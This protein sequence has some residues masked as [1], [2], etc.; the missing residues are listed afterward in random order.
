MTISWI[1]KLFRWQVQV[2]FIICEFSLTVEMEVSSMHLKVV[3]SNVECVGKK[4]IL[5]FFFLKV[6]YYVNVLDNVIVED[7]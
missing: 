6:F 7:K 5:Y 3:D 1:S 2:E 4:L